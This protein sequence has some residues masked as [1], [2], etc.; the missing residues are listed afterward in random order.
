MNLKDLTL[1]IPVRDRQENILPQLQYYKDVNCKKIIADSSLTELSDKSIFNGTGFEYIYYGPMKWSEKFTK[2]S[3]RIDTEYVVYAADDDRTVKETLGKCVAFLA[4]NSQYSMCDGNIYSARTGQMY[5][6]RP[7]SQY[8][9]NFSSDCPVERMLFNLDTRSYYARS[10]AVL[11]TSVWKTILK[12]YT[13][14]LYMPIHSTPP[15]PI[16]FDMVMASVLAIEGNMKSLSDDYLIRDIFPPGNYNNQTILFS[17]PIIRRELNLDKLAEMRM[18][19]RLEGIL[20][21]AN[22]L[23]DKMKVSLHDAVDSMIDVYYHRFGGPP[24]EGSGRTVISTQTQH[25]I[26]QQNLWRNLKAPRPTWEDWKIK[27]S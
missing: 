17:N 27:R 10:R 26:E 1:F 13:D 24:L 22:I 15:S 3:E 18:G 21:V 20:P 19:R 5:M 11:R 4:D 25:L 14:N 6:N 23:A 7:L 9:Y 2:A 12:L 8:E 16:G